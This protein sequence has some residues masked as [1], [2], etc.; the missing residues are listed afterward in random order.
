[1]IISEDNLQQEQY[2]KS[3]FK[4]FYEKKYLF[5]SIIISFLLLG[6]T[7]SYFF[8]N[9]YKSEAVLSA[10]INKLNPSTNA[11]NISGGLSSLGIDIGSV[12]SS[13]N[14][15]IDR[16]LAISKSKSL[17]KNLIEKY[18]DILPSL[19]ASKKYTFS[20]DNLTFDTKKYDV[21]KKNWVRNVSPPKK[22]TPSFVEAHEEYLKIF[23]SRKN[24]LNGHVT[25]SVEHISPSFA[26]SFLERII[27][28]MNLYGQ[29]T[30][31]EDAKNSISFLENKISQ[32]TSIELKNSLSRLIEK[33]LQI[34]MLASNND[35]Y[36]LNVIDYPFLPEKKTFPNRLVFMSIGLL[37]GFL[38]S[39]IYAIFMIGNL[40]KSREDS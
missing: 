32:N 25:M 26:K 27:L 38:F 39:L 34:E 22:K 24:R 17:L 11:P 19:M 35:E 1:M 14:D 37:I 30:D 12:G 6:L 2:L 21:E 18:D 8:P 16:A 20:D 36:L 23:K 7:T 13:G 40:G 15:E 9:Q 33:Q 31:I 28:E 4:I 3:L 29:K 5:I 10:Q